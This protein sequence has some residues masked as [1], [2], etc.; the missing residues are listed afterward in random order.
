[1]SVEETSNQISEI[2]KSLG[3]ATI[4]LE[5]D[6]VPL[7]AYILVKTSHMEDNATSMRVVWTGGMD[8]ITRLG[9]ATVAYH[10]E[11]TSAVGAED[12]G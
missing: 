10:Q 5:A 11:T 12:N 1:M 7:G 9:L 6:E 2:V 8:W 3:D 4:T